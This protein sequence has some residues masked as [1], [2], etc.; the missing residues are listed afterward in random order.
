[1]T[2]VSATQQSPTIDVAGAAAFLGVSQRTIRRLV[3]DRAIPHRRMGRLVRF[4]ERDLDD[5]VETSRITTEN[6]PI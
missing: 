5:Y 4:T 2:S 6:V 1:M 3:A